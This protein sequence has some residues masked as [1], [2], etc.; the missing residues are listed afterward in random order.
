MQQRN[1]NGW[2][3]HQIARALVT[4]WNQ[5]FICSSR[6]PRR[7]NSDFCYAGHLLNN[8]Q[9]T[10][11]GMQPNTQNCRN[12]QKGVW[13]LAHCMKTGITG[14]NILMAVKGQVFP[15][16]HAVTDGNYTA[17]IIYDQMT[18]WSHRHAFR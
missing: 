4:S 2:P 9:K 1:Q 16:D 5:I 8:N 7:D 14:L 3:H 6:N 18:R 10:F 17:I 11:C 12:C 13:R 15:R